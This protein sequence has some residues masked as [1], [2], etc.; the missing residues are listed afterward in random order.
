MPDLVSRSR[1]PSFSTFAPYT[2][3]A[4]EELGLPSTDT[5]YEERPGPGDIPSAKDRR[6]G[7]MDLTV[8]AILSFQLLG[9]FSSACVFMCGS[10][11]VCVFVC[12]C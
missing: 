4:T 10:W 9:D 1:Y 12:V 2:D 5:A 3:P 6:S 8:E 11:C 7:D